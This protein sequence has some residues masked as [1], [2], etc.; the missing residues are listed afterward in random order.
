MKLAYTIFALVLSALVF[1]AEPS[2]AA[3]EE[4]AWRAL[5]ETGTFAAIRHALAP[6][7]GD[8]ED[9]K[10]GD[11]ATQRNLS[12]AGRDQ[13]RRIGAALRAR[14][15]RFD[16]VLTSEWCR[17]RE[18]AALLDA[19][20]IEAFDAL[21]ST[22]HSPVAADERTARVKRRMRAEAAEAKI[23]LST[24]QFNIRALTGSGTRSGELLVLR[25]DA[26]GEPRILGS[27]AIPAE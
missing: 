4:E 23:L 13:A 24:H 7:T 6:G 1:A 22:Y 11:C 18:T 16:K 21:N 2:P 27:I 17:C 25:L 5:G 15:I 20:P 12:E 3:T 10:L 14:G 26:A 8:P 19:G 9:F